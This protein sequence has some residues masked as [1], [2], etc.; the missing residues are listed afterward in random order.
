MAY[1]DNEEKDKDDAGVTDDVLGE[2][3]DG[4]D[5]EDDD[6][7]DSEADEEE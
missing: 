3:F 2:V 4:H 7:P 6:M 5:D 1:H